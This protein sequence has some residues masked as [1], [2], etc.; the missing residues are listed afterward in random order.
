MIKY[1]DGRVDERHTFRTEI[2]NG[3]VYAIQLNKD[4]S[5]QSVIIDDIDYGKEFRVGEA[6]VD[7][8]ADDY[9]L[10]EIYLARRR[11][12]GN[13]ILAREGD[14]VKVVAGRKLPIGTTFTVF[15]TNRYYIPGTNNTKWIDYL[16]YI[17]NR[18]LYRCVA[19]NCI[20]I[21]SEVLV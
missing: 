21:N 6:V 2:G 16:E 13:G 17:K 7:A 15:S 1:Y 14:I 10:H 4:G 12:G 3:Y 20:I 9:K 11:I 18:T 5:T 8:T 19:K